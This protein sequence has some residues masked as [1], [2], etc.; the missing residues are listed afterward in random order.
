[1]VGIDI[2]SDIE[3]G[4]YAGLETIQVMTGKYTVTDKKI[5]SA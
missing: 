5:L 1:M 4:F 2:K 3:G